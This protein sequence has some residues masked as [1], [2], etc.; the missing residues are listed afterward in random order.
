MQ[1]A[2]EAPD[3]YG[4]DSFQTT[5]GDDT[6]PRA[7]FGLHHGWVWMVARTVG[8]GYLKQHPH[9]NADMAELHPPRGVS[10]PSAIPQ[11]SEAHKQQVKGIIL[12]QA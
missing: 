6:F 3:S 2:T 9:R 12:P 1:P 4:G 5:E 11:L 10:A 7:K 8:Q